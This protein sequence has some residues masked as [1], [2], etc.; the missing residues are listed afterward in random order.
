MHGRFHIRAN[1]NASYGY[2]YVT[3]WMDSSD[4]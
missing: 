4:P 3:A 2:L 1:P